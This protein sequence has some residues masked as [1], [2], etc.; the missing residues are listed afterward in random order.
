MWWWGG[1]PQIWLRKK[2]N[3]IAQI[4]ENQIT[5]VR[6][7]ECK[8]EKIWS[9]IKR[10]M[11][12]VVV[13]PPT[14]PIAQIWENLITNVRNSECKYEKI[15]SAIKRFMLLLRPPTNL[16][17]HRKATQVYQPL[18]F[19]TLHYKFKYFLPQT[20]IQIHQKCNKIRIHL[21]CNCNPGFPTDKP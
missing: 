8:Y 7:S 16:I 3:P 2:T 1:H 18:S 6:N 21:Y 17:A 12:P 20:Q 4:W 19:H 5:N 9:A 10:F 14:N 15:W 13:R 11:L